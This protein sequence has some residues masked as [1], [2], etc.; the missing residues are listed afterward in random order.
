MIRL[1]RHIPAAAALL[2]AASAP[3]SEPVRAQA[4]GAPARPPNVVVI[5]ADDLGY[6]DLGAYGHPLI[7]TPRLDALARDGVRLTS[8]YAGAPACT[9]A[10]A[11]C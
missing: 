11:A 3:F 7:R 6:G 5:L 2:A 9:P 8:Y 10:R 4:P 1:C